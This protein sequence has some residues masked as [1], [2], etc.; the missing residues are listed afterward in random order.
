M[1][2]VRR[3][4]VHDICVV[5]FKVIFGKSTVL[6]SALSSSFQAFENRSCAELL[7]INRCGTTFSI[8]PILDFTA[9]E[10]S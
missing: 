7:P 10:Y 1:I 6:K 3:G 4:N 5:E 9:R 2:N 8:F